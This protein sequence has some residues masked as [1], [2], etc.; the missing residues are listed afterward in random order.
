MHPT[1]P[2]LNGRNV[3]NVVDKK[4]KVLFVEF[5]KLSQKYGGSFVKY[6]WP[7]PNQKNPSPK[8]SYVKL[9]KPWG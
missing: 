9:F 1:K 7:K 6:Y 2:Q 4:G 8:I 5:V 3:S